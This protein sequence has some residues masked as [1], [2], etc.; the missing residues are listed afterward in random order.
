MHERLADT[1]DFGCCTTLRL[2]SITRIST[3]ASEWNDRTTGLSVLLIFPS[4]HTG[5]AV[6]H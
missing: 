1:I 5:P 4:P 2:R 6:H 3:L